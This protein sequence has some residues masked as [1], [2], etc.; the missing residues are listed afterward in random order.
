MALVRMLDEVNAFLAREHGHYIDGRAVAGRGERIDVCDPSTRAVIGS[1]AQATDDD[2]ETALASSRRAFGGEWASLTPADRERILLRFADLIEAHGEELAQIETAQSGKLIG[3]SRVIEVGW[4]ARWLRYYAGWA[5]KIAGETLAPS[6][7]SM[8]GERYTSFTL[9]E[10]L[11]VVF[12]IIPWN[13]PV[14]IPVWKFGA[15]LAT[16]NTVL[17]KSSEYTPLTML[18]IA[19]LATEAGL[20]PG[21][22][23]VI[24]GTGQ[25]GAKVIRDPRVAKV[26]FT[27]SVPTGRI[28]GEQAVNANF[29]RFTLELGGKNAA[30]FLSDTP[31]DKV[32]DGIVEAGF[33]HSGQVCASAERFFVHR[34]KFDEVVGKM[35]ARLDGFQ[36]ADPMDDAG[37]IGPVCNESQFRKCLDAFDLARSEGDTIVTGGGAYAR[38]GFYVKPTIVLPRSLE[39]ASYRN[40]IFGPVGAF[41]PFD[42][43]EELIAM[44]NDTPFGLTASLWTNDLAKALRYVPR[45]EAGTVW[46]NM[47]TLVDPAV[48]FGGAKGSGIGREYGSSFI[49]A[50]TEPKSVTI[51]F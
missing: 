29:T 16:G 37:M 32:L 40:E 17:I 27:G 26:S 7:P 13:F 2:V 51:R 22:L 45:I 41:V 38:D 28:I 25:V 48:P 9:R 39:S 4:S 10:P 19:E 46:V 5:T 49:D 15:A 6:F 3:L 47:H 8:N 20:P 34:S 12:G 1:V 31:V 42:D 30:A 11:G 43:D 18:R 50:Y 33:L 44:M 21:T 24:N 35:Q 36:P 23:N 14:M